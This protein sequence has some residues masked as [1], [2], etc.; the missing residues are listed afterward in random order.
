M[1]DNKTQTNGESSEFS[2]N[3]KVYSLDEYDSLSISVHDLKGIP[4]DDLPE[5][6]EIFVDDLEDENVYPTLD[7]DSHIFLIHRDQSGK[8]RVQF[9][10]YCDALKWNL[11]IFTELFLEIKMELMLSHKEVEAEIDDED[12]INHEFFYSIQPEG[13]TVDEVLKNAS[14]FNRMIAQKMTAV[15][16]SI[17]R[18][19]LDELGVKNPTTTIDMISLWSR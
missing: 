6:V 4:I 8:C 3:G 5:E 14:T 11:V 15:V 7:V 17:P 10:V 12:I 9:S 1:E 16:K 2:I 18:L 13:E 19:M